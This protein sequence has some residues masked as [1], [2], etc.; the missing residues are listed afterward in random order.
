MLSVQAVKTKQIFVNTFS[1]G[2]QT[3][4]RCSSE[5]PLN[6]HGVVLAEPTCDILFE[7]VF[8]F[9]KSNSYDI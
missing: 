7:K 6:K 2:Y 1:E 5:T 9:F 3:Q 4:L 8:R